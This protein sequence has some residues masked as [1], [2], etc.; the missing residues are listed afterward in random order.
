MM[1]HHSNEMNMALSLDMD[2]FN[3]KKTLFVKV[4]KTFGLTFKNI[5]Q[6]W[7]TKM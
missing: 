1:P 7:R 3:L 2:E 4:R 5:L 6:L